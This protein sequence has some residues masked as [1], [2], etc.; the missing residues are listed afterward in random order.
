MKKL[1]IYLDTSVISHLL[2]ADAPDKMDDTKT[3]WQQI[4]YGRYM[5]VLSNVTFDE[6]GACPEPKRSQLAAMVR[7]ITFSVIESNEDTIALAEKFIDFGILK[8]KSFD[9]CRHLAAAILSDCDVVVSWNFKHIVN[10]RTMKGM[11]VITTAEGCKDVLICT[12]TMLI[13][14]GESDE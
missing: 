13:G 3:L 9:D 11:R 1:K 4:Q 12:P 10:A 6:L 7:Q 8:E 14:E 5:A 2:A